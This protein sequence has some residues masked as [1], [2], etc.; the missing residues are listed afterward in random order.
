MEQR[1]SLQSFVLQSVP[2]ARVPEAQKAEPISARVTHV[3][4]M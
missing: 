2:I 3:H 1:R 4:A